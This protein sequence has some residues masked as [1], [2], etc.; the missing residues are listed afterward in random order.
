MADL[1]QRLAK[2]SPAQRQLLDQRLQSNPRA[3]EPIAIVGMACRFPQ[4]PDLTSYWRIIHDQVDATAE[5]PPERWDV[6]GF[7]DPA[8]TQA[9]KMSVRWA[10]ML[11]GVDQFEPQFFGVSPREAVKM[12]PQQ[13]LLLEV[14]WESLEV[15]CLAPD[16]LSG[17]TTGVFIG[18]GGTDYSKIL[19]PF[20]DYYRQIDAHTGTGNA[21]S[22]AANRISYLFDLRGPSVAVDTAC[23]SGLIGVHLAIQSLRNRECDVA[24]AGAVNL[25]LSPETTIAFSQAKMLSPDGH[26]RPFDAAANGYVRGEGCGVLVLKRLTEAVRDGNKVWAV[27]RASAAN[28]DGRTSGITAPNGRAQQSVIRAALAQAGLAPSAIGYIEAHGTGTPLGDP[29]EA[30]ALGAV[31]ADD[32]H[33]CYVASVKA[34]IGHTETVSGIA[35]VIKVVLMLQQRV[36]PAQLHFN[37]LN[38]RIS[39][40]GTRLRIPQEPVEWPVVRGMRLAGVSSFGFGG[41]NAHVILQEAA[42]AETGPP[43]SRRQHLLVLSA[44]TE[45][46]L[47][48]LAGNYAEFL[49]RQTA[50]RPQDVCASANAGR[51]HFQHRA[52]VAAADLT[53]LQNRL[54][55]VQ[56]GE[57]SPGVS[58]GRARL[59][60]YPKIA[61]LFTGQGS[62]YE[63]MGRA[64]FDTEPVFRRALVE[65]AEALRDELAQPL[66]DIL[67]G[68]GE[69]HGLLD[70]TAYTQPAL[71]AVEYALARLWQSWGVEPSVLLGHS[72]G[73]YVAACIAGVF[74]LAAGL[75]LIATRARLMQQLPHN[76]AMAVVF[77]P[78]EKVHEHLDPKR[79]AVA[80]INGPENTVISGDETAVHELIDRFSATGMHAQLLTVS[81][82]FHSPLM[83]P[84]LDAFEQAAAQVDYQR[85]TIPIASNLTGQLLAAEPL[86]ARYWRDH[87][88]SPVLF[89]QSMQAIAN[90]GVQIML[91]VGPTASLLGMGKRCLAKAE[92]QWLP[93]LR[94]GQ[95]DAQVLYGSVAEL[96]LS[97]AKVDWQ[98]FQREHGRR[99]VLLPTYP[100]ER[101]RHWFDLK[102]SAPRLTSAGAG[103]RLHP[104]LGNRVRSALP[105]RTFEAQLSCHTPTFLIEHQVQ[106][107]PVFPAAGYVELAFAAAAQVLGP[108]DYVLENLSIQQ[109]LYLAEGTSRILQFAASPALGDEFTFEI[110]SAPAETE[111]AEQRWTLHACGKIR[112]AAPATDARP[113]SVDLV[114][115]NRTLQGVTTRA[116]FYDDLMR[117]R[118]LAYGPAFQVLNDVGR[119]ENAVLA[120]VAA[121]QSVVAESERFLLHPALGDGLFQS[122]AGLV[123]LEPDGSLSPYTYMPTAVRSVRL[124]GKPQEGAAIYGVRTSPGRSS[125]P[126]TVEGDLLLLS[127]GG[128]VLAEFLGVRVQR[129]GRWSTGKH[130]SD[131]KDW[132]YQVAWQ[133]SAADTSDQI[134]VQPAREPR[135]TGCLIFADRSGVGEKLASYWQR[136]GDAVWLVYVGADYQLSAGHP[137]TAGVCRLDP[138][139]EE[140]LQRLWRDVLAAAGTAPQTVVH[141]WSLDIGGDEGC[142]S[143]DFSEARRRG[144]GN[145]LQ[146]VRQLARSAS[147]H[148]PSLFLV[149]Q[150]AQAVTPQQRDVFCA[151][152]PL[153]GLGRVVAVEHP[154]FA[155]R[156]I[157]LDPDADASCSA[158]QV[159]RELERGPASEQVA[160][161]GSQRFV[162]RLQ[163]APQILAEP[164]SSA[165][166]PLVVPTSG[167]FQLRL[168]KAGSFDSL[169]FRTVD[170]PT[171]G[172]GQVQ[173][174]VGAAGLNFSD[175]LKAMGLYPGLTDEIVPLG[176]ECAGTVSAVGPDVSRFRVGDPVMGVA[177]YS[178]ASHALTAEYALVHRPPSLD[179]AAAATVPITFLTA[180]YALVK[181]ARLQRG[182]R[183]LIHAGAG[184]VGLAAIQIAQHIGA[185]I[186]ATAGSEPKREFLR[187][188]GVPFVFNSRTLEFADQVREASNRE[189]VDVVLNSLPGD[190]ITKSL[191]LL[192]AYGRFLEIG[193]T[194]IYQNR[195]LG[196]LPFQDNLS[197]FAID[198]DRMLRQRPD[199]IRELF[200]EVM[201]GFHRGVLRP[202]PHTVFEIHR[203]ADAFR[204]LAQ[205]KNTGKVVVSLARPDGASASGAQ[206]SGAAPIA[207]DATYL[208]T[209][210]LGAVGL[211]LAQWLVDRKAGHIA[212]MSRRPASA[213]VAERIAAWNTASTRVTT[214]C[215]DVTDAVSLQSALLDIQQHAPPLRGVFHAAGVLDDGILCDMDLAQLDRALA[216]K[217]LGAWHLHAATRQLPLDLFVMFSSV[218][219]VLGSPGQGNYAAG[220]AFLDA[221]AEHR[222]RAG[223]PALS[224]NWGPWAD[225]GMAIEAGVADQMQSRGMRLLP[226][227]TAVEL[228][229]QLMSGTHANCVVLDAQWPT[230]LKLTADRTPA[231]LRELQAEFGKHAEADPGSDVDETFLRELSRQEN[232]DQ[233]RALLVDYFATELARIMGTDRAAL[234]AEQPLS[235]IGM[236]S[237]LAMELKNNLERRLAFSLPMAA[238]LEGPSLVTLAGHAAQA[239]TATGGAPIPD[240]QEPP[241]M[242]DA[243]WSPV[244]RLGSR[245]DPPYFFCVHP[246]G[247]DVNCY[248]ALAQAVNGPALVALRGRG[249]E[250][251]WP[252]HSTLHEMIDVYIAALKSLQPRGPYHIGGWSAGGIFA[253]ELARTLRERGDGGGTLVLFDSPPPSVFQDVHLADDVKFLL[254]LGNF[255]NWF[256]GAAIDVAEL[257]SD[258]L[259]AMDESTRWQFVC[260]LG[261]TH[262]VIPRETSPDH[263]RRLVAAGKAHA[264]MI[265]DCQMPPFPGVVHLLRPADCSALERIAGHPLDDDLG[266]GAIVGQQLRIARV[267]GDHFSMLSTV[268]AGSVAELVRQYVEL[269][270]E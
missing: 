67:F 96:Y 24:L 42:P 30:E 233:R 121:P 82:A 180:H 179:N 163:R 159:S 136:S 168:G 114:A 106:G 83:E 241:A 218:A 110:Y 227:T 70:E 75:R 250:G 257:S 100:F 22:I 109:A 117:S 81:H 228:L 76:G 25:I 19:V 72:V 104:L 266:W 270:R 134:S 69:R 126:E 245:Q 235:Q 242:P 192:R 119:S 164:T 262:G 169:R 40:A 210:G 36:I 78:A 45:T 44:K 2:L 144:V 165:V 139:N 50:V 256:S 268:H 26:C 115:V 171:P 258:R 33:P 170:R 177:P 204:Y 254:E 5:I 142:A 39:L 184:G 79:V 137:G 41:T 10:G 103:P 131:S 183:V 12:D 190:A 71:F 84:M 6:E 97:G 31:F 206:Q 219:C 167:T 157:D 11:D 214:V 95:D 208:I 32:D 56:L 141:L 181:L 48:K 202:L 8:G 211:R 178:F 58:I 232:A 251:R 49:G 246:L 186:Y 138:L 132:I 88:R 182:E 143:S 46:A 148:P 213:A 255:A 243:A 59:G 194:D 200:T 267:P 229:E 260:Q 224:I 203:T 102:N 90:Q 151:Q 107:S 122:A 221:L 253:Y 174:E 64:L 54:R 149:T 189:G 162:A 28:Q 85:P 60:T 146:L 94:K 154:E 14:A 37:T 80:A 209:G 155:C 52:A 166:E 1:A 226:P 176:I 161:R 23:S 74:D 47:Q 128:E 111:N 20:A 223:L 68:T 231:V 135:H 249:N 65:C 247:G 73:E 175:V 55:A 188:I 160:F 116:E 17:T 197:Y 86:T 259:A 123:P 4:A 185:E 248:L 35:G 145:V 66:L 158:E 18:I 156:L 265:R 264:I 150:G 215:A 238:F 212:L 3:A 205:R 21:L 38:P 77:A 63:G 98:G 216:P 108:G 207:D 133:A 193:K 237:L 16:R 43:S 62:Q 244:V 13:R 196:L 195:M 199:T 263:L 269:G 125:S 120:H 127:S 113:G 217:V 173:V 15:A 7:F 130:D 220:N 152:A 92:L 124:W 118:G 230:L 91:E 201:D 187:E 234:D 29:I 172:P 240:G 34:N 236:D 252:P 191:G 99:N 27:I 57:R 153:W 51:S 105:S 87:V 93:S 112:R 89:A 198:L 147:P 101:T 261:V 222:R 53:E 61:F 140:H 239:M 129:V 225:S 9:G